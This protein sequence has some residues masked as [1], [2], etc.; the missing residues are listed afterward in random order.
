MLLHHA[1][2]LGLIARI[3]RLI[4]KML[5]NF[6]KGTVTK[7]LV[8]QRNHRGEGQPANFVE[9]IRLYRHAQSQGNVQARKMLE[10][11]FFRLGP[12]GQI[13]IAWMQQ[14]AY[15]NLS[16][17]AVALRRAAYPVV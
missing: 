14:L 9:A 7:K 4:R 16:K 17:D 5:G 10:L 2:S 6:F 13:D 11:I 8:H 1:V 12:D 3:P 15:V